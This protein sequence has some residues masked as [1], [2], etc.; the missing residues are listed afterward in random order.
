MANPR[1]KLVKNKSRQRRAA[2]MN[3]LNMGGL[4]TCPNCGEVKLPHRACHHC[5]FYKGRKVVQGA[6]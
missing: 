2:W 4:G 5:G 3:R 1:R 6:E